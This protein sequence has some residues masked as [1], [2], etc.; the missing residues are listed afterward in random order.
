MKW[1]H[2]V[3]SSIVEKRRAH[4]TSQKGQSMKRS[5]FTIV[6]LLVVIGIIG[7]LVALLLPAIQASRAA[8]RA[9]SCKNSLRQLALAVDQFYNGHKRYPPGQFNGPYK[10]KGADTTAWSWIAQIL[11]QIDEANTYKIGGIPTSTIRNSKVA[12][13]KIPLLR[14]PSDPGAT[15]DPASDRR[16][17]TGFPVALSNYKAVTGANWGADETLGQKDI[18]TD[19]TNIGTNGSYDG[20]N[21]PDGIMY[22]S[23]YRKPRRKADVTD[24]LSKTLMLGEDLPDADQWSCSW[25]FANGPY[26]TCAIP[27]N[28]IPKP[29]ADYTPSYWQNVLSFRSGHPGGLHFA[30][31]DDHVVFVSDTID[32][33]VYRALATIRGGETVEIDSF[34]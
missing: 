8:A 33:K 34:R 27:P 22:R 9:L 25:A 31:A 20:Q 28:V 5:G 1:R 6:E 18:G 16:S 3:Y 14:C 13:H 2:L 21:N 26:G 30:I 17:L 23:D 15:P 11:P 4:R 24:G 19:W 29:G 7:I 10:T 32:L 12:D